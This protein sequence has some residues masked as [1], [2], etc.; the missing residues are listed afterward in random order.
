MTEEAP[1]RQAHELPPLV[2]AVEVRKAYQFRA[3][4]RL[5]A[6]DKVSLTIAKGE[7][8]GVVGESGSGKTTL[9]RCLIRLIEATSG[10]ILFDGT[11]LAHA[12]SAQLR[13]LRRRFQIVFQDPYDSL[14]PRWKASQT[15][16]E[17]LKLLTGMSPTER[18]QR[19]GELLSLV[20][21]DDRFRDRY[22]HQLSGGQQQ[23][24]GIARALATNPD[25]VVLDEPTS[26]LDALVRIEILDLLNA[27]RERLNLTYLYISHDIES[28]RRVCTRIAV[29]YLGQV[30][31]S[32]P[33]A[34]VI[35]NPVHPYTRALMSAVLGARTE[36]RR[37]RRRL[38]GELPSPLNPPSGCRF[39]TRCPIAVPTCSQTEQRLNRSG[40]G[41]PRGLRPHHRGGGDR[42]ARR[43]GWGRGVGRRSRG[44][45][46]QSPLLARTQWP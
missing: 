26:A 30:V 23:R 43:V 15:L 12:S 13:R 42:L 39:H 6:V 1:V 38:E 29:M 34:T 45:T 8:L 36:V 14:N 27:L 3:R 20:R 24:V 10:Q 25:L 17:P 35:S 4:Q 44:V 21:L 18:R 19:V 22:P 37:S 11:D 41:S 31:E 9:A 7:S 16:E 46:H 2:S 40:T 32:G 33:A 28:V 5:V